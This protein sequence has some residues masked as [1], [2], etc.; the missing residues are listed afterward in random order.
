MNRIVAISVLVLFAGFV[1][2]QETAEMQVLELQSGEV[3]CGTVVFQS[4]DVVVMETEAGEKFQYPAA[5]VRQIRAATDADLQQDTGWMPVKQTP[6][7]GMIVAG[8]GGLCSVP[9]H[10][11]TGFVDLHMILGVRNLLP[12]NIFL[13]A[14]F[15][16][17]KIFV[18]DNPSRFIPLF[19]HLNTSFQ[20]KRFSPD[21]SLGAGYMFR[22]DGDMGSGLFSELSVGGRY[23][24]N[25]RTAF[26]IGAFFRVQ[27]TTADLRRVIENET[28]GYEGNASIFGGGIRVAL[29]F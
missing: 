13:G 9:Q 26:H 1:F 23:C 7:F 24:I 4:A 28:F 6:A 8:Q 19:L 21:F 25:S 27:Q 2:A 3:K 20:K 10:G 17:T 18:P 14:G 12:E 22:V 16:Y 29:S 15:G 11:A 5:E